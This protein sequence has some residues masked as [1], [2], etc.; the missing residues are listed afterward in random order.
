M[1]CFQFLTATKFFSL[2]CREGRCHERPYRFRIL[3][4][5]LSSYRTPHSA[6]VTSRI[7]GM[8]HRSVENP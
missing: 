6:S 2:A 5:A 4:I 3:H 7:R 8:V 1:R